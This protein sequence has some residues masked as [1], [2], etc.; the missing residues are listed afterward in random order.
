[1]KLSV[2][3]LGL[4][5]LIM[6]FCSSI[7]HGQAIYRNSGCL[8]RGTFWNIRS[9]NG[10]VS[11]SD[12]DEVTRVGPVGAR[13]T[14]YSRINDRRFMEFTLGML[15]KVVHLEDFSEER[16]D[17]RAMFPLLLGVRHH[18]LPLESPSALQPYVTVGGGPY[19]LLDVHE[20]E[21][22]FT[23]ELKTDSGT[24]L[25]LYAGCGI[26][27]RLTSWFGLNFDYK[28]HIMGLDPKHD[29]TGPE[30]GIGFEFLWGR[31]T[32]TGS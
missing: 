1:M 9:E 29:F 2:G 28:Y 24:W 6:V 19:F 5:L 8:V 18:F 12:D 32:P 3:K 22:A 21:G 11:V 4:S 15:A 23:E 16:L 10:L 27:Y 20:R 17:V 26:S 31:Y 13:L 14:L 30:F 7:A 25:G